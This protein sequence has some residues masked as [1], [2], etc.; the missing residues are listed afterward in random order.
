MTTT[1]LIDI[2]L[3]LARQ[4]DR[5]EFGPP[6][7]H[8]YNPLRYAWPAHEQYLLR[9][10][11]APK[12]I[13]FLGMNPGPFGMAQTGVPFGEVE[14]VRDWLAIEAAIDRPT[15]EHPKR[16]IDGFSCRRSEVSGRRLWSWAR[17]RCG[18]PAR[19]FARC[20]V[21][22]YCPLVFM[23]KSGANRTPD[24]L[25]AAESAKLYTVC[26]RA[27]ARVVEALQVHIV[28]GIGGFAQ[29]RARAALAERR[30]APRVGRILHPSPANPAAN[31]NWAEQ[32]D[33]ELEAL[34][35]AIEIDNERTPR[36]HG[37]RPKSPTR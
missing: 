29:D 19:F 1:T 30:P 12:P 20:F 27:L 35:V 5:L 31:R 15:R 8:V 26:N 32:V 2:A 24:K 22:N 18:T 13:L 33:R 37:V 14:L 7:T 34:D 25:P 17:A 36:Q 10:G 16:R 21:Y 3:E 11:G 9:Y 28:V 23:E 6:V 4:V